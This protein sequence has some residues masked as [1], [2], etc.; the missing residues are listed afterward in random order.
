MISPPPPINPLF[1]PTYLRPNSS[2]RRPALSAHLGRGGGG[3]VTT[4]PLC[5][6]ASNVFPV[7]SSPT[8]VTASSDTTSCATPVGLSI[9]SLPVAVPSITVPVSFV[10]SPIASPVKLLFL[11][12]LRVT[13][14]IPYSPSNVAASSVNTSCAAL[15]IPLPRRSEERR[16]RGM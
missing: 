1:T 4:N 6:S 9:R 2:D 10:G 14:K 7:L 8:N 3:V 11:K 12:G 16:G 5:T 15:V 13:L